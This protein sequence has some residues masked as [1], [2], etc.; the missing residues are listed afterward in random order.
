[1]TRKSNYKNLRKSLI[2]GV[3]QKDTNLTSWQA[4]YKM[5][6]VQGATLSVISYSSIA[7]FIFKLDVPENPENS[8]F[9][10]LNND[11]TAFNKPIYS[12]V[13]KFAI[14]SNNDKDNLRVPLEIYESGIKRSFEKEMPA[15][16]EFMYEA[17]IQQEIYK[18]TLYPVGRPITIGIIDFAYFDRTFS[19]KLL[20]KLKTLQKKDAIVNTILNYLSSNVTGDRML[21]LITMDLVNSDFIELYK[22]VEDIKNNVIIDSDFNYSIAQILLL[23]T[24]TKIINYDSHSGNILASANMPAPSRNGVP[25]ARS[26]LIDFGRVLRLNGAKYEKLESKIRNKYDAIRGPGSYD[27]DITEM[28]EIEFTDLYVTATT[29]LDIVIERMHKI[30]VFISC[31]D[32]IMNDIYY[33][34]SKKSVKRGPQMLRILKYLYS[35]DINVDNWSKIRLSSYC[36][37]KYTAIIPLFLDLTRDRLSQHN[38]LS[39]KAIEENVK[40]ESIFNID[41]YGIYNQS[42]DNWTPVLNDDGTSPTVLRQR[43]TPKPDSK[44]KC[45]EQ[46]DPDKKESCCQRVTKNIYKVFGYKTEGGKTKTKNKNKNKNKNKKHY[47]KTRKHKRSSKCKKN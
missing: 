16:R 21:G 1:M 5:I 15:L 27:R 28:R 47:M 43:R 38:L 19:F 24:K 45:S 41:K 39:K 37:G 46:C 40:N 25:E 26:V 35:P 29:P 33:G 14:L 44:Q 23:F 34:I 12:L 2:G 11:G 17:H 10:G 6:S 22:V 36:I 32:Y 31:I 7:G 13:F 9:L 8:Q 18:T 30:F 4:V 3:K 20:Q 42:N